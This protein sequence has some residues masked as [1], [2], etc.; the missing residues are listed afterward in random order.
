MSATFSACEYFFGLTL[1][2]INHLLSFNQIPGLQS[3][4]RDQTHAILGPMMYAPNVYTLDLEQMMTGGASLTAAAGVIQFTIYNAKDLKNTELVGNSDPYIKLRLGNRPELASTAVKQDTLNPVWNE[5]NTI[6]INNLNE[7]ICMEI[8]DKDNLRKD[9][10]LGQA[11]FD[12]KSLE[13]EPIQDDVWC[14]V[15]RNG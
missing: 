1:L 11:N 15:L 13:E 10:P 6:L 9:R 3:F 4:V 2:F 8:L 7:V 12:L 5:T 14:K